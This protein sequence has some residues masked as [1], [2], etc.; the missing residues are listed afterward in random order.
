[1]QEMWKGIMFQNISD[2]RSLRK[3]K[4]DPGPPPPESATTVGRVTGCRI[5]S[6]WG[7]RQSASD[8]ADVVV[9]LA[10][11]GVRSH[12]GRR[13][14]ASSRRR[15]ESLTRATLPNLLVEPTTTS[16]AWLLQRLQQRLDALHRLRRTVV[17]VITAFVCKMLTVATCFEL[18]A[19][20]HELCD[21]LLWVDPR[22]FLRCTILTAVFCLCLPVC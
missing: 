19:C 1:M 16:L 6:E 8:S 15:N 11:R 3:G 21:I 5:G 22:H 10:A 2:S 7:W 14:V 12:D 13:Q 9:V 4:G 17:L 18:V 20:I